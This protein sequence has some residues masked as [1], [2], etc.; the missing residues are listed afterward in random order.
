MFSYIHIYH[1][2]IILQ[3]LGEPLTCIDLHQYSVYVVV[4]PEDEFFPLEREKLYEAIEDF[5]LNIVIFADWFNASVAEKLGFTDE[6]TKLALILHCV[7]Y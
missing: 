2:Y 4:D 1:K 6:N 3:V 5:G 7:I